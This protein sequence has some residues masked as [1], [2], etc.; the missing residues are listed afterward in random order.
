MWVSESYVV[1]V[2]VVV[3]ST[4]DDI[5]RTRFSAI[6]GLS[7]PSMSF[8]EALVKSWRPAIGRY[9]WLSSGSL[10]RRSSA[11]ALLVR[12]RTAA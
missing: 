6:A 9:S 12:S 2:V 11:C 7:L 5:S 8:C 4:R 1:V 10:R 3:E